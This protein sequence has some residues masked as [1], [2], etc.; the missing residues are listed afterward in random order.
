MSGFTEKEA[1]VLNSIQKSVPF[2]EQPFLE[3]G[4]RIEIPESEVI[5]IISGLE[6]RNII[7]NIAGIF[8]G[9]SLGYYLSL[10][11]LKVP[12]EIVESAAGELSQRM[13]MLK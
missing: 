3:I 13:V 8:N 6:D 4:E 10:V 2:T 11:A 1:A 7:R 9:E 5:R 12:G